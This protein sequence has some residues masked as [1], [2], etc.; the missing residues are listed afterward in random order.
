MDQK[1][2]S[3]FRNE[4]GVILYFSYCQQTPQ[5]DE[6]QQCVSQSLSTQSLKMSHNYIVKSF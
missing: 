4:A 1:S 2:K 3:D 6:R 5:K